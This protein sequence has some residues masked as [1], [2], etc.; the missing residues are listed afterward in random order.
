LPKPLTQ[1]CQ[2]GIGLLLESLAYHRERRWITV[3]L[4]TSSMRPGRNL[5]RAVAPLYEPLDTR[6]ADAK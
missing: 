6:A 3:G 4:A 1:L 2:R 5:A